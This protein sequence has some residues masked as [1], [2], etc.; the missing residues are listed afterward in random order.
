MVW[1]LTWAV[2][3]GTLPGVILGAWIR[4]EYLPDS[5]NFKFFAGMVLLYIGIKL[6]TDIYK[7]KS[8]VQGSETS[9]NSSN[10]II[11]ETHCSLKQVEFK[12]NNQKFFFSVPGVLSLCFIVGI[13]GGIY[14]IGGGAIIAPFFITI[15]HLPVYAIAG[16][17]L[18]GTLVTSIVGVI[19]YQMLSPLYSQMSVAP[20]WHLGLLLGIGGFFGMYLGAKCQKYVPVN[21]IKLILCFCVFLVSL[22]YV[23]DFLIH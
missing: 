19:V 9:H 2:I 17:A 3:I 13:I 8:V 11:S 23:S 10:F 5:K 6:L 22:K 20:D 15:F 12:F 4:L 7:R 1:P 18:M 21:Y 14:G 16:A